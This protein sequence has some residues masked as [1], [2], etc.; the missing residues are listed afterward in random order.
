MNVHTPN[1]NTAFSKW[2]I[3]NNRPISC[4]TMIVPNEFPARTKP[5]AKPLFL[6]VFRL[7]MRTPLWKQNPHPAPIP[8]ILNINMHMSD[9]DIALYSLISFCALSSSYWVVLTVNMASNLLVWQLSR[10][11]LILE[12]YQA[13]SYRILRWSH[14]A[15]ERLDLEYNTMSFTIS[16][17]FC[18]L[19]Q[20]WWFKI[21]YTSYDLLDYLLI[22][23]K[24]KCMKVGTIEALTSLILPSH[25]SM[26]LSNS[27]PENWSNE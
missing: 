27:I 1:I 24:N 3:S 16:D 18:Y 6:F 13:Y 2:N 25:L 14:K 9:I 19:N 5:F 23:L 8:A 11:M 4:A 10:A 15:E 7:M 21:L 12:I 17:R 20:N 22:V 26:K